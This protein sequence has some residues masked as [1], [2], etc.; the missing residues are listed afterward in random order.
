MK[1]VLIEPCLSVIIKRRHEGHFT[2]TKRCSIFFSISQTILYIRST[3]ILNAVLLS[4][5]FY[6]IHS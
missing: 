6:L 1:D 4:P 5:N 3:F 2:H